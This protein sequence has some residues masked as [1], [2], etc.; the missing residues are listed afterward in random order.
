MDYYE[1]CDR[2]ASLV[3]SF[4]TMLG[5]A[6]LARRVPTCPDWTVFDLAV[7]QGRVH[8]WANM[9]VQERAQE[10]KRAPRDGEPASADDDVVGWFRAGGEQLVATLRAADPDAPMWSWGAEQLV[11]FW[12]R[13]QLHETVIHEA[14][15]RIALGQ[16]VH[17]DAPVAADGIDELLDNLLSARHF[18]P[19]VAELRGDGETLHLHA[20]DTPDSD[21]IGEWLIA[22]QPDGYA[23]THGHGKGDVA[24]R[25]PI[26]DLELLMYNRAPLDD[27]R[28]EVFGDHA[29][30]DRWLDLAQL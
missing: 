21:G 1:E 23:Y 22:L 27:A 6:D 30:L 18:A 7:H 11:R 12:S 25:G 3:D 26:G 9:L 10:R 16:P 15:L 29:L 13:R 20:T 4:A 24:V 28:F 19:K 14:D 8:R 2:L 5:D 17:I